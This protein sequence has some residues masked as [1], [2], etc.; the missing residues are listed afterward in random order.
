[1]ESGSLDLTLKPAALGL[2]NQPCWRFSIPLPARKPFREAKLRIDGGTPGKPVKDD[3]LALLADAHTALELVQSNPDLSL[4]QIGK[5]EGRCRTHLAR[6]LRL[7]WL[8]PRIVEA[9]VEGSQPR[10]I[11]RQLLLAANLPIEWAEQEQ[12]FGFAG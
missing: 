7:A 2:A 11:N 8:S 1:V 12:L 5:R 6:L 3:L 4:H 9:V 10:N